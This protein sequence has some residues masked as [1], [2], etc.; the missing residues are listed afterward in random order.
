[1][2]KYSSFKRLAQRWAC[3]AVCA[4]GPG[5]GVALAQPA[6]D[7]AEEADL[8]FQ[9]GVTAY[10][11]EAYEVAL[12]HLLVSNRLAPNRN[13]AFNI[14]R[15]YE[16]LGRFDEAFRHYHDVWTVETEAEAKASARTALD[17]ILPRVA[18]VRVE[19]SP[20]GASIFIDRVDLGSRGD[21]PRTLALTP[22]M[23]RVFV[24]LDGHESAESEP[25]SVL[26]G[27][28]RVVA[29][30]LPLIVGQIE[31]TGEPA[32]ATVRLDDAPEPSGTLPGTFDL[33][34]GPHVLTI[35]AAGRRPLRLP[36]TA[37]ARE[38]RKARVDLP[39]LTGG[40]V[41]DS[42]EAGALVEI[43]G[44][45]RGFTPAVLR[46][47]PVG[48]QSIRVSLAGFRAVEQTVDIPVDGEV[49]LEVEL[50]PSNEV[51]GAS[52]Q[53]EAV[54]DAPASVTLIKAQE[55]RAF[56]YETLAEALDGNR[57]IFTTDDQTF[58]SV[59]VR[60]FAPP[61]DFGNRLLLTLDGHTL[62]DDVLGASA[63]SREFA[64]DLGDV[65]QI[66][67]I[68]GPGSA[69]YGT[70]AF[71]GVVNVIT[72]GPGEAEGAH[73]EVAHSGP[74][75]L[76]G[77]AGAGGAF[78]G[79]GGFWISAQGLVSQGDDLVLPAFEGGPD[80]EVKDADETRAATLA[81]KAWF[82]HLTL[83][84]YYS[85][86]DQRIGTAPYGTLLADDRTRDVQQRAFVEVRHDLKVGETG[87]LASRLYVDAYFFEGGY[88]YADPTGL[89]TDTSQGI[90]GGGEL[91][92]QGGQR[93]LRYTA[94]IEAR[95]HLSASLT[96]EDASGRYLDEDPGY[97]ALAGYGV[98][99]W[100]P[101]QIF[102]IN[103]GSRLD[104]F[105]NFSSALTFSPRVAAI[106]R[107]SP[108]DTLKL[109]GGRSF[110]APSPYE[111]RYNDGGNT[112][113]AADDLTPE[114][115]LT[116]EAEYV[117]ALPFDLQLVTSAY[118][119]RI[120]NLI[121]LPLVE[122]DGAE[123]F[124]YNNADD[125]VQTLGAEVEARRDWRRG[126]FFSASYAFQRTRIGSL[127]DDQEL[128]NSPAHLLSFKLATPLDRTGLT[129]A[130]R[131]RL[132]SP[133]I[134][135]AGEETQVAA[136][137]D[138]TLTGSFQEEHLHVGMGLRNLLDWRYE[139]PGGEE[140]SFD[141]VRQTGRTL[142]ASLRVDY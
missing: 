77:R 16:K 4:L 83:Q 73:V 120:S 37:E 128:T 119:N 56:G 20:P 44:Q 75:L 90:W 125:I 68:R 86:R 29:L 63:L 130:N 124:Q 121:G 74:R 30:T 110:R 41:I 7:L 46:D 24:Q 108:E 127:S 65:R 133:R 43:G 8:H 98:L 53:A 5:A 84:G 31:L 10:R 9:R 111:L 42:G 51:V 55:I 89:V 107:P 113:I 105:S 54:E 33:R 80:L 18:L 40:L 17:R 132:E 28:E 94:G 92:F 122:V 140:L 52:R 2:K 100:R 76:R 14:G 137:W 1:V 88:A 58:H 97:Y 79:D 112:W 118:Y 11:E 81:A 13:V 64:T 93:V 71:F 142:W 22:G 82:G 69:L 91:R 103:A 60:G 6:P 12:E 35:E 48:A 104:F 39:V 126:V 114:N 27:N 57:G 106:L 135:N 85:F 95:T 25:V 116:T 87:R 129:L 32:G 62:N 66:E 49:R 50:R 34:P 61:G 141:R 38:L 102:S 131:L 47:V 21:T 36:V 136:L 115:I 26:I 78:L 72:A 134:T 70:S 109:I 19:S 139:Q 59:G 67:L 3:V 45:A 101:A 99:D 117:R 96:S 138:V 123:V 15:C 23:H